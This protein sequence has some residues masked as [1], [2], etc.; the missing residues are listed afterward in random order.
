MVGAHSHVYGT[1]IYQ[2]PNDTGAPS[3]IEEEGEEEEKESVQVKVHKIRKENI[4]REMLLTSTGRDK[5]FKLI[6]YGIRV[7]LLFHLSLRTSKLLRKSTRPAWE[8]ELVKRLTTAMSGL[9][10][11]RKLLIAFNWLTPLTTIMA[12]QSVPFSSEHTFEAKKP[13]KRPLLQAAL[14]APP[15]VLLDL[16]NSFSD[17]IATF[18]KL[19]LLGKRTGDRAGR[20]SD[21]CWLIGTMVGL[22]EN[23]LERGVMKN[24]QREVESRM[25]TES[26]AGATSKSTPRAA[27]VDEREL[28]RLR[29]KDY[30]LGISRTK[31]FMDLIFVSYDIMRIK[32]AAEP[33]KAIT[34]LAA[35]VLSSMKLYDRHKGLLLRAVSAS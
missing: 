20:F 24:L 22:I 12:Q 1:D 34:G 2:T 33:V 5:A 14:S 16:V 9:S 7:Y 17:D 15:P 32:R 25:Y 4:W 23:G 30:W 28:A 26:M 8:P 31:L 11:S 3:T 19:G 29:T 27:R 21:W 10:L 18:S 6:Q 13:T 35:A